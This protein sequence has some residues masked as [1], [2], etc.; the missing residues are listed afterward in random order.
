[1]IAFGPPFDYLT[2]LGSIR[3]LNLS[4]TPCSDQL[5]EEI[6][7]KLPDLTSLDLGDATGNLEMNGT[8]VLPYLCLLLGLLHLHALSS[9]TCLNLSNIK[10]ANISRFFV[11][12][13]TTFP[14]LS[15]LNISGTT[16]EDAI[17]RELNSA[18]KLRMVKVESCDRLSN[19]IKQKIMNKFK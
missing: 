14:E 12:L 2:S 13:G 4:E 11:N 18:M 16:V 10:T 7:T 17:L 8:S 9:L 5:L 15:E 19:G 3:D 6:S 1:M